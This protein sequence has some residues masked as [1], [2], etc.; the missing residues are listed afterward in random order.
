MF[1]NWFAV[2]YN[3]L[4]SDSKIYFFSWGSNLWPATILIFMFFGLG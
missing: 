2:A 1:Q 3:V 4:V